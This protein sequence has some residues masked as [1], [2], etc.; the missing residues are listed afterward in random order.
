MNKMEWRTW[1][2]VPAGEGHC[3]SKLCV[4]VCVRA[5]VCVH[6]CVRV[7]LCAGARAQHPVAGYTGLSAWFTDEGRLTSRQFSKEKPAQQM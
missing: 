2:T 1:L 3:V 7:C 4:R 5:F 6:A